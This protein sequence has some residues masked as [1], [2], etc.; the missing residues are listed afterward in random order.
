MTWPRSLFGRVALI[1]LAGLTLSYALAYALLVRE[2]GELMRT[3][4]LSYLGRDVATAVAILDRV[5]P[6]ERATWLPRLARPNYRYALGA[7]PVGPPATTPHAAPLAG[8]LA[9]ALGNQ[10]GMTAPV[11]GAEGLAVG[12]RLADGTP[13]ALQV[14]P[15][16]LAVSRTT[17]LLLLAQ[18]AVLAACTWWAVRI[19]TRPL[20]QL[21]AAADR[22]GGGG[23]EA[24]LP[25]GGPHEVQRAAAAFNA[26]QR[27]IADQAAERL[28]ILAAVSHDLRTPLTR[29][30]MRAELLADGPLRGKLQAD[31]AEMQG[32][33]EEGLAYA[34]S[35]HA[36]LEPARAVDLHALLD[37]LVCDYTDAGHRVALADAPLAPLTT[38]PQALRRIVTN[39]VDNA[40]R[41]GGEAQIAV[42]RD[43]VGLHIAV[44]DHGP[45]IP[46]DQLAAVMKPFHRLDSSRSR[47]SGGA[48]LGLAIAQQLAGALGASLT[49]HNR[50]EGGLEARL[51]LL[52]ETPGR[53]KFP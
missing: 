11:Q 3:S 44:R 18:L 4:M 21:A 22:I 27:R 34:R 50:S 37:S 19:A 20:A 32:L 38:R 33:V 52:K 36:A 24:L 1:V 9:E 6:E 40:L 39:L 41:F 23:P 12:L 10:R 31:L 53:P 45:G 2:R 5:P 16:P 7:A 29:M 17:L 8:A 14:Q 35:A 28:Q 15:P 47:D 51:T 42:E 46:P 49:L 13:L 25:E 30:R 43:G 48:G 26:M